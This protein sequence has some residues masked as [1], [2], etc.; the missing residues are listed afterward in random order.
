MFLCHS[1]SMVTGHTLQSPTQCDPTLTLLAHPD[2]HHPSIT[3]VKC[4]DACT[5]HTP[6][7]FH[8]GITLSFTFPHNFYQ[9]N[10]PGVLV[11]Y[12]SHF[13]PQTDEPNNPLLPTT[14]PTYTYCG[15]PLT[16]ASFPARPSSFPAGV[17]RLSSL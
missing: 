14:T 15:L 17:S 7:L 2:T 11:L 9:G 5:R 4:M 1:P 10:F 16:H 3:Q 6:H 8:T 12:V 13:K